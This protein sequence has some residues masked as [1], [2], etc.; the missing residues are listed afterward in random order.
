MKI[1]DL[2]LENKAVSSHFKSCISFTSLFWTRL[3][4]LSRHKS[5]NIG[6]PVIYLEYTGS[7]I[8]RQRL[9]TGV[10]PVIPS[11]CIPHIHLL[12]SCLLL[13]Q[14]NNLYLKQHL[15]VILTPAFFPVILLVRNLRHCL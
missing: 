7:V 2:S 12:H 8:R 11:P 1:R 4:P 10:C 5:W 13:L 3:P 6:P 9:F 15:K 14:E